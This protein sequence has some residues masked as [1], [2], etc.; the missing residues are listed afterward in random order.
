MYRNLTN[1]FMGEF[2]ENTTKELGQIRERIIIIEKTNDLLENRISIL[3]TKNESYETLIYK[4]SVISDK[5]I[6]AEQKVNELNK[7]MMKHF[8]YKG[9]GSKVPTPTFP[10]P[11]TLPINLPT[12]TTF[13]IIGTAP[14]PFF[15]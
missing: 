3:Q 15:K 14:N 13:P 12:P 4:I 8:A 10:T 6:S 5:V 1:E 2:C 9:L 11:S 7:I